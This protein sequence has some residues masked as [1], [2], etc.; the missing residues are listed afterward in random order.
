MSTTV[1]YWSNMHS[2]IDDFRV[3]VTVMAGSGAI[4]GSRLGFHQ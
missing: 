3:S 4:V 1:P 2:L